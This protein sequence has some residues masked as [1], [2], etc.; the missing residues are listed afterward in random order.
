[1]ERVAT[2]RK[3]PTTALAGVLSFTALL[4]CLAAFAAILVQGAAR[5]PAAASGGGQ[6]ERLDGA[7]E[8]LDAALARLR[9]GSAPGAA[10][11]ALRAATAANADVA[12]DL[13]RA[14]AAGLPA[15][16]RLAHAV[17]E[18]SRHLQTVRARLAAGPGG[19]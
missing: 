17:R 15:D 19:D 2:L 16:P 5:A 7:T 11:Q 9:S 18:Q 1:M 4:V 8:R 10:R 13:K 3:D 14:E 12:A 6:L